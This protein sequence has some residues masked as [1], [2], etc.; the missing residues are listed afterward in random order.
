MNGD[1]LLLSSEADAESFFLDFHGGQ[2]AVF[3]DIDEF[4]DLFDVQSNTF[5]G[6][7]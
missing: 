3:H 5:F 1:D 6:I 7:F 2:V 4:F